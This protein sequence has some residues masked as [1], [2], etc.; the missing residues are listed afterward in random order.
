MGLRE[1]IDDDI[2]LFLLCRNQPSVCQD[3]WVEREQLCNSV[4]VE[5]VDWNHH[6]LQPAT[7]RYCQWMEGIRQGI[8]N[9]DTS[10]LAQVFTTI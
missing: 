5:C 9:Q 6:C 4:G 8:K 2:Q 7:F 10:L 1:G 3:L